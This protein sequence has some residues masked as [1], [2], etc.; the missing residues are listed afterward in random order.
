MRKYSF[1]AP[2]TKQELFGL[3]AASADMEVEFL[4][5]G[6]DLVPR[7]NMERDE[8]PY[9]E[10][11]P[12]M[13]ISLEKLGLAGITETGGRIEIGALTTIEQIQD[14]ELI[15]SKAPA[16]AEAADQLAGFAIRNTATIGGNIMNASPAA[17][18]VPPL[19][20]MGAC[21]VTESAEGEEACLLADFMTGV[22]KTAIKPGA[23]LTKIVIEPGK[24]GTGFV[25]L[26]RRAAETLSVVNAAAYVEQEDGVC[27]KACVVIGS[28]APT[29]VVC[30]AAAA[31]LV[32][33]KIDQAVIDEAVK[34]VDAV[35]SPIDDVRSSAWYRREVAPVAAGRAIAAAAGL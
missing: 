3:I 34:S 11:K 23:I 30:E 33:K 4:A 16:L 29:A 31:A 9:E 6:T 20:A 26:G 7:I 22:K 12:M 1:S 8:I 27:T 14:S 2:E 28:C 25:K 5:G 19:M 32:G 21:V 35:I 18:T 15:R 10:K 24:G 13:I 17:D